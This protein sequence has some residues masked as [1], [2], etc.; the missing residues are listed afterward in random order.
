MIPVIEA[1]DIVKVYPGVRAVDS[2][3]LSIRPGICFG[4]LGPNGA[5][6]TTLIEIIEG[7]KRAASG[8]GPVQGRADRS[9]VPQGSRHSVPGHLAPGVPIS[10]GNADA[11]QEALPPHAAH[12]RGRPALLAR[13]IPGPRHAQAFGRAAAAA[14]H[15]AGHH[16]RSRSA[17]P[18]RTDHRA[19]PAVAQELLGPDQPRQVAGQDASC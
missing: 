11:L 4:L 2:V 1:K 15:G 16:Q 8:N 10:T 17:L 12:R 5:G 19:R 6:K 14:A 7:I 9:C 13:G 3:S 18:G